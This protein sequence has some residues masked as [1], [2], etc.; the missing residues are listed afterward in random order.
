MNTSTANSKPEIAFIGL[1]IMG[2][3]MAANLLKAG[4]PLHVSTRSPAKAGPL[5]A[6]GATLHETAGSAAARADVVIT[7]V[8][9][10]SDVEDIYFGEGGIIE[11][12]KPG[13][14]LIDM[15]T[16]S[17]SLAARINA[18]AE[19]RGLAALDAPVSGGDIGARE[20]R[21]SIMVGGDAATFERALPVLSVMG[22]TIAHQG[23]AGSGQHTK[24]C[25]QIVIAS[26]MMGVAESVAYA[27]TAGLDPAKVLKSIGTGA[28]GGFLL[29]ALGPK[30]VDGDFAPG[31]MIEHFVK[32][33]AIAMAEADAGGLDLA[34]LK[35]AMRQY[36]QRL[37]AG[38]GREGTQ[39]LI[40]S[41]LVP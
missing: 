14:V 5:V 28:A 33:M 29:N 2:S 35:A 7:I 40:K 15:T 12:A 39:A 22:T 3:A 23:P 4:Y 25:N 38:E 1:G 9:L 37:D 32:D 8:G 20:A 21:L 16:S 41:Y 36:R 10:P 6:A 30:M 24:M 11:K 13:A 31:F 18:A 17:P 34:G 27:R 26:T 19:Q